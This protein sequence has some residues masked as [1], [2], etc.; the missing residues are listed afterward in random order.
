MKQAVD[1]FSRHETI[2]SNRMH[3]MILALLLKRKAEIYDNSYGK[4]S[5]YTELWLK[6]AEGLS[7]SKL[8]NTFIC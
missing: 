5:S 7:F 3:A 8:D 2:V 1:L 6:D 4:L